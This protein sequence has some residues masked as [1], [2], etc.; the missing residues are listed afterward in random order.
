MAEYQCVSPPSVRAEA[1]SIRL[2]NVHFATPAT[3]DFEYTEPLRLNS[4]LPVHGGPSGGTRVFVLGTGFSLHADALGY[5]RCKFNSTEVVA[6]YY[7][8]A[9]NPLAG[10]SC[11][12]PAHPI[13][14]VGLEVTTNDQ[15]YSTSGLVFT[16]TAVTI[17]MIKPASCS[18][19]GRTGLSDFAEA[20]H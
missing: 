13:G 1:V 16:F 7:S 2:Q 5:L 12:S 15:Q 3:L 18:D 4:V 20:R 14:V 11:L 9:Q 6:T 17:Q 19:W 10:V 8:T